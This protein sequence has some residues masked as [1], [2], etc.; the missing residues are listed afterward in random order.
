MDERYDIALPLRIDYGK[1]K[2]SEFILNLNH[3][4]NA[5][6]RV[7][8]A[9]KVAYTEAILP[10]VQHLPV[11]STVRLVYTLYVKNAQLCDTSNPCSIIDKFFSDALVDAKKIEDDN[12]TI[13]EGVD[14]R[15]GGI[16]RENPR[17]VVSIIPTGPLKEDPMKIVTIFDADDVRAALLAYAGNALPEGHTA[18]LDLP[19]DFELQMEILPD[20]VAPS[21]GPNKANPLGLADKIKT[22]R[23]PRG[24]NK[25]KETAQDAPKP[26]AGTQASAAQEN[27]AGGQP[28][29]STGPQ[30]GAKA[31]EGG[32]ES[33]ADGQTGEQTP[34]W[35]GEKQE[36]AAPA[37]QPPAPAPEPEPEK[38]TPAQE[39]AQAAAGQRKSL[40]APKPQT[41]AD[42]AD[43][44]RDPPGAAAAT[45]NAPAAANGEGAPR[46]SLF[47]GLGK[48][49]ND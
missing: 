47:S 39:Q 25:A 19:D 8:A 5:H 21:A 43:D 11:F 10:L 27:A 49:K 45:G 6:Q 22:A 3:Y 38:E 46:K 48:V 15:F 26:E 12:Y 29:A 36:A 42:P 2:V 24:P 18:H 16:D 40:F 17:C 35:E 23:K 33:Q 41:A 4:R 31:N 32:S 1:K 7:L 9:A 37:A 44:V 34:P 13:V 28:G 14:Y 30:E 20:G